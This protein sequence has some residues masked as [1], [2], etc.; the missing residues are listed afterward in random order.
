MSPKKPD[1]KK[2]QLEVEQDLLTPTADFV[3]NELAVGWTRDGSALSFLSLVVALSGSD[4]WQQMIP[5]VFT[6]S[7]GD[8]RIKLPDFPSGTAVDM[9]F[10]FYAVNN[11][12]AA[13][14]F[15]KNMANSD[16]RQ[17]FPAT[18]RQTLT[19]AQRWSAFI[20]VTLF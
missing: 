7:N 8:V 11:I 9:I 10:N 6:R 19:K 17:V 16:F 3:P 2:W 4:H 18:G 13:A 20:T 12:S 1:N 5:F 15:V 14:I